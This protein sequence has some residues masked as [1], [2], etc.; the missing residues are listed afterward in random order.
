MWH[1]LLDQA[2]KEYPAR[3]RLL[4]LALEG[5]F[6][7]L[8]LPTAIGVASRRLDRALDIAALPT[9]WL[10]YL[11]GTV[12]VGLGLGLALW[13]IAVQFIVGRGTPIPVMATQKLI[14]RPP[15][16]Y[17][18]NPMALGT[19]VAYLGLGMIF[20]SPSAIAIVLLLSC[21]LL[22]FIKTVEE[23]EM[24]LRFGQEYLAYRRRTPFL[25]P[26]WPTER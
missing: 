6:F 3:K 8:V 25:I 7:L 22:L 24:V 19:I 1:R 23:Q 10:L 11:V 14:V 13:S 20:A 2:R 21:L 15:Y 9:G 12:M 18:R 5:V 4:A 16:R 17:T 26:R